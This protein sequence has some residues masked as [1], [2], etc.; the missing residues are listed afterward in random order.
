[1]RSHESCDARRCSH[2][3]LLSPPLVSEHV[4]SEPNKSC[5]VLTVCS[6]CGGVASTGWVTRRRFC[7][8][9]VRHCPPSSSCNTQHQPTVASSSVHLC[10]SWPH[11]SVGRCRGGRRLTTSITACMN[12]SMAP[13]FL[14]HAAQELYEHLFSPSLIGGWF[15]FNPHASTAK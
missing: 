6:E 12:E 1:M 10:L 15:H 4:S 13:D 5:R 9:R 7:Y 2:C 3:P 14:E 8:A 11:T